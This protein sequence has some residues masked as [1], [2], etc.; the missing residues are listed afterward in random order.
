MVV[1]YNGK[2]MESDW[3][4]IQWL[5]CCNVVHCFMTTHTVLPNIVTVHKW[6]EIKMV[7]NSV[8]PHKFTDLCQEFMWLILSSTDNPIPLFEAIWGTNLAVQLL[9]TPPTMNRLPHWLRRLSVAFL[10]G[11]LTIGSMSE[12]S[13]PKKSTYVQK[14]T[15]ASLAKFTEGEFK[16]PQGRFSVSKPT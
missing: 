10:L 7:D 2:A 15:Y 14:P 11:F 3:V 13:L 8:P 1:M 16:S 9:P 6:V 4:T 12:V 5:H